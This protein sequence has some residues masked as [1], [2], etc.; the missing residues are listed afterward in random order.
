M[1]IVVL[2]IWICLCT[3][4]SSRH[5]SEQVQSTR[6]KQWGCP[7]VNPGSE[8]STSYSWKNEDFSLLISKPT[9]CPSAWQEIFQGHSWW[10]FHC[11]SFWD[12]HDAN[13]DERRVLWTCRASSG[14]DL[15]R[16]WELT[17]VLHPLLS[18]TRHNIVAWWR[19]PSLWVQNGDVSLR[20]TG[21]RECKQKVTVLP[22]SLP[23]VVQSVLSILGCTQLS[24]GSSFP[25]DAQKSR[26]QKQRHCWIFSDLI[27]M[28][29]L[30]RSCCSSWQNTH[31]QQSPIFTRSA[32]GINLLFS[33]WRQHQMAEQREKKKKVLHQL[34]KL[35]F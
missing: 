32:S 16:R 24:P 6:R 35:P 23:L 26:L 22:H 2:P 19:N 7:D 11:W 25:L 9:S 31:R 3:A 4:Q 34:W 18:I 5:D 10:M 27:W 28:K 29:S 1:A 8:K 12:K 13:K 21:F 15:L 14:R 30:I 33:K 17:Q 20:H